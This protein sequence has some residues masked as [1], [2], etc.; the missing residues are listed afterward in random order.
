M[1]RTRRGED[2][3]PT[4]VDTLGDGRTRARLRPWRSGEQL[5]ELTTSP[6]GRAVDPALLSRVIEK[7][8]DRGYVGIVTPALPVHELRPYLDHGFH[9]HEEL[10]LLVHDLLD[11]P[12]RLDVATVRVSRRLRPVALAIDHAAFPEFWR[13]DDDALVEATRATPAIRF[14]LTRDHTAYVLTGRAGDR[15]YLQRLAVHPDHQRG[16][17]GAALV[18]DSLRWL[19]RWRCREALVNTQV[20]NHR[21]L[22]LYE[23]TGFRRRRDGL[24]VLRLDFPGPPR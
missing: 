13:L 8:Q 14:R 17:V 24:A 15:G 11:L 7:A 21:A 2:A 4:V 5:A 9:V 10:H 22:A 6:V 23:S 16:G 20:I 12:P 19:R 1:H 3:G 18:G